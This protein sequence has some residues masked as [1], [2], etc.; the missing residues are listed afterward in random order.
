MTDTT[1]LIKNIAV[2]ILAVTTVW[3]LLN[4]PDIPLDNLKYNNKQYY[5]NPTYK[6]IFGVGFSL[7]IIS[8][9]Y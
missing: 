6:T 8:K 7:Y 2:D 9:Y 3:A 4:N 5:F 1:D